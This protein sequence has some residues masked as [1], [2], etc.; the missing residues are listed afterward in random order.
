MCMLNLSWVHITDTKYIC[1]N[2]SCTICGVNELNEAS[3]SKEI[4]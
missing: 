1:S 3:F 2:S 4:T